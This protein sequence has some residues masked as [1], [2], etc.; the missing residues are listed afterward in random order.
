MWPISSHY[1]RYSLET[2]SAIRVICEDSSRVPQRR[3]VVTWVT[4]ARKWR[5]S[6]RAMRDGGLTSEIWSESEMPI[7]PAILSTRRPISAKKPVGSNR[8]CHLILGLPR[9]CIPLDTDYQNI[10]LM[11]LWKLFLGI[12]TC[13]KCTWKQY[14]T[15]SWC[16]WCVPPFA[17]FSPGTNNQPQHLATWVP[18]SA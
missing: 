3:I 5:H 6:L 4:R 18:K 16:I 11:A 8:I 14:E 15:P 1:R 13:A 12:S 7:E 17:V 10:L 2:A 9:V